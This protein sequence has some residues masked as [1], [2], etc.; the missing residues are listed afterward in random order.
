MIYVTCKKCGRKIKI[1]YKTAYEKHKNEKFECIECNSNQNGY[2]CKECGETVLFDNNEESTCRSCRWKK[3]FLNN[4]DICIKMSESQKKRHKSMT[5]QEKE[6]LSMRSKATW[7]EERRK[8]WGEI[9]KKRWSESDKEQMSIKMSGS[10]NPMYNKNPYEIWIEKYGKEE[11]DKRYESWKSKIRNSYEGLSKEELKERN[12]KTSHYG[13][14]NGMYGK[15]VY[16]VW[17]EKYGKEEADRRK[18]EMRRKKSEKLSGKN[19]PMYGKSA[20]R[21]SGNGIS[22]WYK[23]WYF[24]SLRELSYMI[25]VIEKEGHEWRSL[26]NTS[27][28]RIKYLDKDGHERSYCPDFLIDDKIVVEIKPEKLQGIECNSRKKDAA[29]IFC[30]ARNYEYKIIDIEIDSN[31]IYDLYINHKIQFTKSSSKKVKKFYEKNKK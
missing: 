4:K 17:L 2:V 28:F 23:G 21:G 15:S 18:E 20:P 30:L 22:G 14:S 1:Q 19:N 31:K 5:N 13:K 8:K 6:A 27:D 29:L 10:S 3:M 16:D 11:A 9:Q 25:N 12:E 24:R 26:D 7:N